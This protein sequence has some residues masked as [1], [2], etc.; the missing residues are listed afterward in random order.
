MV[1]YSQVSFAM[2]YRIEFSNQLNHVSKIAWF[3]ARQVLSR[4]SACRFVLVDP[5]YQ[6]K[7]TQKNYCLS[8]QDRIGTQVDVP[9]GKR[10][11]I[12]IHTK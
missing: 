9:I 3:H 7:R 5:S 4:G 11:R 10:T 6:E 2:I 12:Y 1:N 8:Q